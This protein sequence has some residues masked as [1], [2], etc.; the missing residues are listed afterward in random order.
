[1]SYPWSHMATQG[2]P[3]TRGR[4]RLPKV[5]LPSQNPNCTVAP[6]APYTGSPAAPQGRPA[7]SK[8]YLHNGALGAWPMIPC[9]DP[10]STCHFKIQPAQ[11]PLQRVTRDR[12]R[13]PQ[14]RSATRPA[15]WRIQRLT[16]GRLRRPKV[17]LPAQRRLRCQN[18]WSPSATQSRPASRK[19]TCAP[20]L[21]P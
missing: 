17:D 9:V 20:L 5:D 2:Q 14:G 13:R 19:S 10:K 16:H 6:G 21:P 12:L 8:S 4:L 18:P 7:N 15:Q 11:W 1:M 3:A